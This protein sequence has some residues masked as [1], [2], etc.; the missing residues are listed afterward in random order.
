M[1]HIGVHTELGNPTN[2]SDPP[3]TEPQPLE[4]TN[5]TVGGGS[6]TIEPDTFGSISGFPPQKLEPPDPTIKSTKSGDIQM[7][8][9]KFTNIGN[10]FAFPT[11]SY[12]KSTRSSKISLR[13]SPDSMDPDKYRPDL[14]Q[15]VKILANLKPTGINPKPNGLGPDDP[16]IIIGSTSNSSEVNVELPTTNVAIPIPENVDV[17]IPENADVPIFQTQFQRIDL[18]SLDYDPG[19]RKQ[20]WEYHVNQRDEI[21]RAYIKKGPHQP[22]LETFKKSGKQNRSFQAS[23]YRNNSKWLEYSPTTDVAYCLPCFVFH[24]PNVVVGQNTFIVGGF[25]NWKKVGGKDCSFQVHIGK[26]PNSAHRVAEQMCKDLMNQSQHLQRV[27]DHFTTEQIVNNRL[28]LKATIFIV[29]YLAFQAIAFRGRDESFSSLNRGNFHES[30]GIV[31]FWNEKVAEIIEKAPKNVTYTSPRIQKEI[32]HVFSAKVKKAIQE[33]IGDAKF[34]IMVDEARDESMK[35]QMAVVFRYVDAEGFVKECFFGLIHVVDTAALT[36]KKGIYSLL[37][38]YCLDIQNIRGQGYDGASNMRGMWNGL[39]ALILNDCPYAYY[40]HCF[41][42]HL[43][44]T[45]VKVSKQVV[46]ISYFF[47]TLL[48]LI[49]I[50]SASCKRNEQLKVANANEIAR[51]IDLEELET[52]SGLNQIG[53]LQRPGETRWSSH[54]RSVFSLLRMFSSIVEFL[55][56]IIDGA[57]D[58]E[59]RAEGEDD[60]WDGLLTTVISFCEKHRI[61]VLDMNARYVA[62]R[63]RARNQPDNVTNEHHYRVNIFYATIDS[64]LQELNYR[65]NEDAMELLRLSSVLE[66]R[67]ALKSFRI[68]DLCLLVKNFYPQ[69]FTDYDKQVLEKELYHFEHNVVQDPE[70]KK[71]KSLSELS[72]WLVR[73]GN[74]NHY[75]LVYRMVILVLTLSVSTATTER[76]FSAMKLVKTELR[77]KMEDDFLNDSLMLYIEKDIASTFSLDSIVDDF[78]DLKERRVPF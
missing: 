43:Q 65:F 28:Q 46:P 60:G 4:L 68:S 47:L 58:G 20:I 1:L 76:A 48:F 73:T 42:H 21:R 39:Q 67:E 66:P 5:P 30:L 64:Q 63:G 10:I 49:K 24:N 34:C 75:K 27:V 57:I 71:L 13:S 31:T 8:S 7:F 56:N 54:F 25:R 40:I 72:Q 15:S 35:E 52:G 17:P 61:D 50:V 14:D 9:N 74:S 29:R 18:D 33:E 70:F 16:T 55:Q 19:T 12:L 3:E 77:N 32:L 38:Q 36:L 69:D 45:L 11:K 26:D 23:W 6:P 2:S 37:S 53:T 41:A 59:N 78:E 44:L 51:L 62:R 22:P